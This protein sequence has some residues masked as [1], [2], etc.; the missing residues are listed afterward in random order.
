MMKSE[1]EL[2]SG[3]IEQSIFVSTL[4]YAR[5]SCPAESH[6]FGGAV[7][8]IS[9]RVHRRSKVSLKHYAII[10][11]YATK[12]IRGTDRMKISV[13]DTMWNVVAQDGLLRLNPDLKDY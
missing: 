13:Y 5:I 8:K 12:K 1:I 11:K 7:F 9:D 6:R 3:K 10:I 2:A 4:I